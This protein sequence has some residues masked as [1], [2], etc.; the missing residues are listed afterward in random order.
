MHWVAR[1]KCTESIRFGAAISPIMK[2]PFYSELNCV[3]E[4]DKDGIDFSTFLR[5]T[6]SPTDSSHYLSLSPD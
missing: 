3:D 5:S 1:S 4:L 2:D 6:L